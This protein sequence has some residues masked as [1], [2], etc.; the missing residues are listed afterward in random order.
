M[1]RE[2]MK[3]HQSRGTTR[4]VVPLLVI[5]LL[6]ITG[7]S[8]SPE[9]SYIQTQGNISSVTWEQ[10]N[11]TQE[12]VKQE[13]NIDQLFTL[14]SLYLQGIRESADPSLYEK[15]KQVME[16]ARSLEPDNN[17]ILFFEAQVDLGRHLF[18]DALK[19][20][21]RLTS[22]SPKTNYFYGVLADAHIELGNYDE[23]E[24]ALEIMINLRPD[25]SS[26]SRIAYLREIFGDREGA[27]E[28]MEYSTESSIAIPENFAW[29]ISELGRLWS[30]SDKNKATQAFESALNTYPNYTPAL[31]GLA[32]IDMAEKNYQKAITKLEKALSILPLPEYATLLAD[33]HEKQGNFQKAEAYYK[34]VDIGYDRIEASGTDVRMERTKYRLDRNILP[35]ESLAIAQ[36]LYKEKPTVFVADLVAWAHFRNGNREE[37]KGWIKKAQETG[38]QNPSIIKH[39]QLISEK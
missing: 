39:S 20:A 30:I 16:S 19:K 23:A 18:S 22:A 36:Q 1:K 31:M 10:I 3:T 17:N 34:L 13:E 6:I 7:C 28:M 2:I 32:K 21:I 12:I 8:T 27:I 25:F 33:L 29:S 35:K 26:Y 5:C 14:A 37:A 38:I 24:Q 4:C 11:T 15:I 9:I